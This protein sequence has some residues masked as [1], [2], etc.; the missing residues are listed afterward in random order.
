MDTS[1]D[2]KRILWMN[3]CALMG[4][5]KP[6]IDAIVKRTKI[7]RGTIQRMRDQKTSVGLDMLNEVA[8]AFGVRAWQLLVPGLNP[9]ALPDLDRGAV[10]W[11]FRD[12]PLDVI[13]KLQPE[14]SRAVEQG[15][16]IALAA[17]GVVWG[18]LRTGTG[19]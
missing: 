5:P 8:K 4:E 6:S 9:N 19:G 18:G 15:L 11:P 16:K 2:P 17:A 10:R 14:E 3:V 7:S 1:N 12:I 13:T